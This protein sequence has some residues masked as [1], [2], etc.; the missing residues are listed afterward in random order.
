MEVCSSA[1][2]SS[3]RLRKQSSVRN[4]PTPSTGPDDAARADSPSA[5]LARILIVVP[6]AVSPGPLQVGQGRPLRARPPRPGV[7]P[8]R[9]RAPVSIVPVVP[10]TSS[11]VPASISMTPAAPTT[12]GIPSCRA[13]IAVWLVGPPRS[14][15]RASTTAGSRVAVS[16]GARSSATRIAGSSGIW[17]PGSGSPTRWATT[18]RSMSRRSVTRSAISPPICVKTA[19]NCS[20]AAATEVSRSSPLRRCLRT[21]ERR[22]L[23]R[24]RP[25]LAVSTSAAASEALSALRVKPSA[26]AAAASS[27][28][29][30]AASSSSDA[31]SN[32]ATASAEI[33]P[34]TTS[35][36]P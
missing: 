13:M 24:A 32:R 22:P 23:S 1:E 11:R 7:R 26:T 12:Q 3:T 4:S 34:R 14:V 17:T 33:S 31:P 29:V 21:A 18:R 2:G 20:T 19:V 9:P 28:A 16:D 36:G 35:A 6:S 25:A 10:S 8:R 15:T 27:Y 30:R 5:T